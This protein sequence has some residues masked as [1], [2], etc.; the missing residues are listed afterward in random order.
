MD[1]TMS[2]GALAAERCRILYKYLIGKG[3]QWTETFCVA[4]ELSRYYPY[5]EWELKSSNEECDFHDSNARMM[6]TND[7]RL[8]NESGNFEKII[9][10]GKRGIKI[11]NQKEAEKYIANQYRAIFRRFKRLRV[12]SKKAEANGQIDIYNDTVNAFLEE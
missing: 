11:A 5:M 6:I 9:I 10:S 3:D 4:W 12:L 2:T 1:K 7:I 8:I